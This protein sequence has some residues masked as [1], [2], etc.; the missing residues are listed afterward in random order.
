VSSISL[1]FAVDASVV[2]ADASKQ[3]HH[4]DDDDWSYVGVFTQLRQ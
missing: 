4:D 1:F 3:K 2:K